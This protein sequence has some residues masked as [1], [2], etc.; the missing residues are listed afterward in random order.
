MLCL[1]DWTSLASSV[2]H[3]PFFSTGTLRGLPSS[4]LEDSFAI[5]CCTVYRQCADKAGKWIDARA[6]TSTEFNCCA[7][8]HRKK[9]RTCS[10]WVAP[11]R[12]RGPSKRP[13][14]ARGAMAAVSS[15]MNCFGLGGGGNGATFL[16]M[17]ITSKHG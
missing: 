15:V 10:G 9:E 1:L 16:G 5:S 2:T 12:S 13:E 4:K 8:Q 6:M 17:R 14:V 3:L 11:P 7:Q